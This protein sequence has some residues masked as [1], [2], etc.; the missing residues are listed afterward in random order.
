MRFA[1]FHRTALVQMGYSRLQANF[2]LDRARQE[3]LGGHGAFA[4]VGN[5]QGHARE[6]DLKRARSVL[7]HVWLGKIV[8][9]K[10]SV[11]AGLIIAPKHEAAVPRK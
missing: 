3:G 6:A 1:F 8:A 11:D 7:E 4:A 9:V 5:P 10:R 2:E